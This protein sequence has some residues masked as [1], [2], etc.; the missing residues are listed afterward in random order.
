L[1]LA[2]RQYTNLTKDTSGNFRPNWSPDGKWIAFSSDRQTKPGRNT[3]GWELLQST[4]IYIVRPDGTGLRRLTELG[5][6]Y[7]SPR[8]SSDG[9]RILCYQSTPR[10]VQNLG[11]GGPATSQIVS[12]DVES[13]VIQKHTTG[14][15]LKTF[16][17]YTSGG[18]IAYVMMYGNAQGLVFASGRKGASS[19]L[20]HPSWSHDGKTMVYHKSF[21]S[22]PSL[23]PAFSLDSA[24]DLFVS[25]GGMF[26]Y[27]PDGAQLAVGHTSGKDLMVMNSDSTNLHT[28]LESGDNIVAFPAWS[29]DGKQIA[30][31][32]G[33]FFDRPVRPGQVAL[34]YPDGSGLRMLTD[35]KSNSGFASWSPD[36]KQ[37]VYRV[38]GNGQ[39]GLRILTVDSGKVTTLTNDYDTFPAW[40]PRGD[41]I[42]FSSFRDGDYDIYTIRP[43]GSDVRKLTNNHGNDAHPAWSAAETGLCSQAPER[44]LRM[45]RCWMN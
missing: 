16:P 36:G 19:A 24:F 12:I 39:Q 22:E 31:S 14:P 10:D 43:D 26:S 6:Y 25:R 15:G 17:Q 37:L 3:P 18:D 13:G 38:M 44:V 2:R 45:K 27:A 42:V 4:G 29:P 20:R 5:A 7:G 8:W 9:H 33:G 23:T 32:I 35:P 21:E 34:I 30:F 41:R 40:S 1:N 28:I 11:D